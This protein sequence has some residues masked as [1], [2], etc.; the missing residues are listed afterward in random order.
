VNAYRLRGVVRRPFAAS[1]AHDY[2]R[3]PAELRVELHSGA[4]L[5]LRRHTQDISIFREIFAAD[6]YGLRGDFSTYDTVIDVGANVGMF[7]VA[8]AG[9][10]RR[11]ISVEPVPANIAQFRKNMA[12]LRNVT[13]FEGAVTESPGTIELCACR[14]RDSG[15]FSR[16]ESADEAALR[17]A[18]QCETLARLCEAHGVDR[19]DL[20]KIDI[21]GGEYDLAAAEQDRSLRRAQIVLGEY[22]PVGGRTR[23]DLGRSLERAGLRVVFSESKKRTGQGTFR[24]VRAA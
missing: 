15:R 6:V 11:V 22:H 21:E 2:G 1:F 5:S 10:A 12:Q 9:R 13:L 23:D 8:I 18:V 14:E 24:A 20:L 7:T 4:T 17:F 3:S 16:Y 19:I